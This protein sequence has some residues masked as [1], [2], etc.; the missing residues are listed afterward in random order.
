MAGRDLSAELFGSP[1]K[2]GAGR[3]LSAELFGEKPKE[4]GFFS[5]IGKLAYEGGERAIGA[6]KVSPSVI[7]G[8]VGPEQAGIISQQLSMKPAVQPK[9]L[10]EVQ[11]AFKDEAEALTKAKGFT[12]SVGPALQFM[13]ELGKQALTNP[14]GVAYLT[15]QS[16]ANMAPSIAGMIA[17]GKGGAALGSLAGPGGAGIG[18]LTG[19]IAGGFAGSAPME[20]GSEFMDNVGKELRTR[21]MEP[22]EDNVKALL[23]DKAFVDKAVS[24]ARTKGVTTAGVDAL[25]TAG[26]GRYATGPARAAMKTAQAE[27]GAVADA[28]KVASRAEEILKQGTKAE[29][30]GRAV[31]RGAGAVGI[32]VLGGGA[33]EAAGQYAAYGEVDVASLGP[34]ML[35][36]LGGSAIEVPGAAYATGKDA[37]RSKAKKDAAEILSKEQPAQPEQPK[38]IASALKAAGMQE[39]QPTDLD[40]LERRTGMASFKEE[41]A[42]EPVKPAATVTP[43]APIA[44]PA[45]AAAPA[46]PVF[47]PA[48]TPVEAAAPVAEKPAVEETPEQKLKRLSQRQARMSDAF[49]EGVITNQEYESYKAELEAARAAAKGAPVDV[50]TLSPAKQEI[51]KIADQLEAAG[52]KG[53][54]DGMR[55]NAKPESR[56]PTEQQLDFYRSK[57][58]ELA[59][60]KENAEVEQTPYG[61]P[62]FFADNAKDLARINGLMKSGQ[63]KV[64]FA[65]GEASDAIQKLADTIQ[66]AGYSMDSLVPGQVPP[67]ILRL[68]TQIGQIAAG[69]S[70]LANNAEAVQKGHKRANPGRIKTDAQELLND[71]QN[72]DELT[73]YD[74]NIPTATEQM[75]GA[76]VPTSPEVEELMDKQRK[77]TAD[78][79]TL[80]KRT[81]GTSLMKVL[82]GQLADGEISE[83]GGKA[84]KIGKNPFISLVAKKGKPGA[85]MENMVESGS[86]DLFLPEEMRP[87][88]EGYDNQESAEYIREKLRAGEFYTN[89]MRQEIDAVQRGVWELEKEIEELLTIED[90]NKEIQYALEEQRRAD[91]EAAEPAAPKE[92]GAAAQ[93]PEQKAEELITSQTEEELKRKQAEIDRLSKENERLAKEAERKAKADEEASDFVLTGSDR[94]ADKAAARGQMELVE[95]PVAEEYPD[96]YMGALQSAGFKKIPRGNNRAY[97]D[98]DGKEYTTLE[99]DGVRVVVRSATSLQTDDL[100]GVDVY[101]GD[102]NEWTIQALIVDKDKRNQGLASQAMQDIV[103]AAGEYDIDLYLEPT[104]IEGGKMSKDELANL[105]SKFGFK[106]Q[107]GTLGGKSVM[108]REAKGDGTE[109]LQAAEKGQTGY[110]IDPEDQR[111]EKELTGKTM[112]QAADWSV[113]NAPNAFMRVIAEKV[114]NRLRELERR[115]VE[116]EFKVEGGNMRSR[117]M[118]SGRGITNFKWDEEQSKISVRLNG[119]AVM[120][121]QNGYPPGTRYET[122]L[123]ELLHVATRAQFKFLSPDSSMG[124]QLVE[125]SDAIIKRYNADAKAGKLPPIM[126]RY[127][128]NRNNVLEDPDEILAWGL[129]NKEVQEYF[130]DIKVGEKSAMTRLVELIREVLGLGKPY[131]SALDRL[132]TVSES[133]LDT[134]VG[135][136]ESLMSVR[137][138][139]LGKARAPVQE[140][141]F[142]REK[143]LSTGSPAFKRWFGKSKAVDANGKPLVVYHGTQND[144]SEFSLRNRRKD[145]G[146]NQFGPGYYTTTSATGAGGYASGDGANILPLYLSIQNPIDLDTPAFGRS[147]IERLMRASPDFDDSLSNFGD[148]GYEGERKVL[149]GA[150][151]GF[152]GYENALQQLSTLQRDFWPGN[153]DG[154]LKAA[155]EITGHD[156]VEVDNGGAGKFFIVWTPEQIKSATGNRGTYDP[157]D[158]DIRHQRENVL[159]EPVA[160]N[161]TLQPDTK[162]DLKDG[163]IYKMLDKNIDIKRVIEAITKESGELMSRWN[164]Y[165]QEELYHGRTAKETQDFM[166]K[167]MK[168]LLQDMKRDNI[169]IGEFEQY[170]QNRHAE[171]YNKQVAKVNKGNDDM[172]DGGSGILTEDA[173]KYLADLPEDKR[174]KYEAL[175]KRIDSITKGTREILVKSGMESRET[176]N[177]WE[178]AFPHYVPLQREDGDFEYT[179]SSTGTGRGFDVR[180][181]FS[182]RAMGSKRQ[183]VDIMANIAL[184]RERAIVKA[185]KNRVAQ[186]VYGLAVQN[187]NPDFWLAVNPLAEKVPPLAIEE[188]RDMGIDEEAIEFLMKEPRQRAVDPKKGQVVSRINTMLRNSDYVLSMRLNGENRYVFFNQS[189]PRAKRAVTALKNLDAEQLGAVMGTLAKV[190]RWMAAVN[191][192]Y[193]PIFGAYNFLRDVQGA[194]LQLSDTPLAGKQKQVIAGTMPAL[195]AI[196]ASMR[197]DRKGKEA[198]TEMAK[199]WADFQKAGG[200][201]GFRDMYSRSQ[202]RAEALQKE[203]AMMSEGK[204]NGARRAVLGWL[205][206]YNDTMENAVRLSAYKEALD[207][208]IGRD[209]AASIAKN[210]TV[211]FN[212]KGQIA[213]QA[214]ALYAFFNAA[215]QGTARLH[216]TLTGPAGKKIMAGGLLLGAMQA[217]LLAFAGFDDEEPPEFVRERNVIIPIGG[218]KYVMFPM[219]LGYHV[220]PGT[221]RIMTE[222]AMSGFKNTGDRIASLTG[223]YLEAFNPIGNA[224]WSVQTIAPTFADP[225]VALAEN[226]DWTGKPIAKKDFNSLDPT[227]GY[228]RAKDAAS[229]LSTK[230]AKFM[231]Y[232]SGGTKYQP[233]L[234]SPTPDQ[235]DYLIGQATGGLGRELLKASTSV[236]KTYTGEELP[237]YKIPV[238]GRF[239]GETTGSAAEASRFY[240]NLERINK[241]E[242]EVKGRRENKE[243]LG[244]FISENPEVRLAKRAHEIQSDIKKLR[245]RKEKLVDRKAPRESVKVVEE[246]ITRK[247]K[248]LNDRVAEFN[249]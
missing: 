209:E 160:G 11:G 199:L 227:P 50:G 55:L 113:K 175:A 177:A 240:K 104:A 43:P 208:G 196:Y 56:E 191:T 238:V 158:R 233:G 1:A 203:L 131:E 74:Q 124:K 97:K 61:L 146:N 165:L 206:D 126:E 194:A 186:A 169:T 181:A 156:G 5:N 167:E 229:W 36:E 108:F 10:T 235:I 71:I 81:A 241:L 102:P 32:D 215:M 188:L 220:I 96:T 179:T 183:V 136:I 77:A 128:K 86:L 88:A 19:S 46:A 26:A 234:A 65:L 57:L 218:K 211:N 213:T 210:L 185:N 130:A 184:A 182:R 226:R 202:D 76:E 173:Q 92:T 7:S 110:N 129:T 4:E 87:G 2:P 155:K 225:I 116:F 42:A 91:Q 242:N 78:I 142:Q 236:E 37:L 172:Q 145:Q 79:E 195:K 143:T 138:K 85:S 237:V 249:K 105:Y 75:E 132:V 22:T 230:L 164:P 29:R 149:R 178:A 25:T 204:I 70:R 222:W 133:M 123:H 80:S 90:I 193:N 246:Q 170:L 140:S 33:S 82:E 111:I 40:E 176:I 141:L 112:L 60:P 200:Q 17:G 139:K 201:T 98:A 147:V 30:A 197:A 219:P 54:P 21:G 6:A 187:A 118:F 47:E 18:A 49:R 73:A 8:N 168:P 174:S 135:E 148:V 207:S 95:E 192:Q 114:R 12:E 239:Y 117:D 244:D 16:A 122:L 62:E 190:T 100:G 13:G 3:D 166:S 63:P 137:G 216:K 84:R 52:V 20:I 152:S 101:Q 247:M 23:Q 127:W 224:G 45:K 15:A 106:Y 171:E 34:E 214:G 39:T 248:L 44:E 109:S 161:W 151:D 120:D 121:N 150:I 9:E 107:F 153:E 58:N 89:D 53:I 51:L 94:T 66:N 212:K 72:A 31:K 217:A 134:N 67:A 245:E 157:A 38:D 14:K 223:M 115:G 231:N 189:D 41:P 48:V 103:D 28:A 99:R 119:A 205:S 64:R 154:F 83:L 243:P 228:L 159:G 27:L 59:K 125:L 93:G 162:L 180:G 24:E 198:D 144:F 68:K 221:S 232:A 69:A 163:F 35:G